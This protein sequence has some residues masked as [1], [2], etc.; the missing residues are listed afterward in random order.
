MAVTVGFEPIVIRIITP[1]DALSLAVLAGAGCW[2]S[3][4]SG[5]AGISLPARP[6]DRNKLIAERDRR[7]RWNDAPRHLTLPSRSPGA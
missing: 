4:H 2:A 5:D 7:R 1:A 6:P 3:G